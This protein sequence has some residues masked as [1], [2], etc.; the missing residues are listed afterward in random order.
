MAYQDCLRII[1]PLERRSMEVARRRQMALTKPPGSLGRLE[2]LSVLLAG[3]TGQTRP[4]L[5]RKAVI[6]MAADHG[7]AAEGVSA[8]PTEVT[9]QMVANFARG[10][11]A[12]NV[13]ARAAG[14]RVVTV[15]MGVRAPLGEFPNV[16]SLRVGPGT[17]N[18]LHEPAMTRQEALLTI[19]TGIAVALEER[20]RGLDLVAT[21][22]MGIGN[23]T[24]ASAIIAVLAGCTPVQVTGPGTG[25]EPARITQKAQAVD[26][27]SKVGGFEIGGLA[28]V[29][30]GAAA[31]RIPVV[32]DGFIAGAAALLAV[33]L[34]PEAG[35]FL[36]AGHRSAEPG[37]RIALKALELEPLL[38]LDLRLGE[39]TGAVLAMP[40][41]EAAARILDEMAT[42]EEAGVSDR[43]DPA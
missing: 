43:P 28:G 30:L 15:D 13:L 20:S 23:T 33:R 38:D 34:A 4:R 25:L 18:F 24:A 37:H 2:E 17:R 21:G 10:G 14:V 32:L 22:D 36:I 35:A 1:G 19:E 6:V 40:L 12:I 26:V 8:Y 3:M 42:F 7:V 16:R 11:A 39:G 27:L 9:A 5:D 41:V 29:I 31:H